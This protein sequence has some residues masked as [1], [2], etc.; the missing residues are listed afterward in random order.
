MRAVL[1]A[2]ATV[3]TRADRLRIT[4]VAAT[5][6]SLGRYTY[7]RTGWR[8]WAAAGAGG[9]WWDIRR[10]TGPPFRP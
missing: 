5:T 10:K 7:E 4:E 1:L 6:W 8:W 3:T 2:I 9:T